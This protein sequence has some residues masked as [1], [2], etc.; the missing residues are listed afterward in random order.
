MIIIDD[1]KCKHGSFSH[2]VSTRYVSRMLSPWVSS[3][4]GESHSRTH[5]SLKSLCNVLP[6]GG[7]LG[8]QF[9]AEYIL[10]VDPQTPL[11]PYSRLC[12]C[13]SQQLLCVLRCVVLVVF[14]VCVCVGGGRGRGGNHVSVSQLWRSIPATAAA[15]A[16]ASVSSRKTHHFDAP[17]KSGYYRSQTLPGL[18]TIVTFNVILILSTLPGQAQP[19]LDRSPA[20]H[21]VAAAVSCST[22]RA[23]PPPSPIMIR[24]VTTRTACR[25][26]DWPKNGKKKKI[27]VRCTS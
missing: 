6:L 10:Y 16:V 17:F 20:R 11:P 15:A 7:L 14:C 25:R 8:P 3:G 26:C 21:V 23:P 12:A 4:G 18:V 24:K 9:P 19:N 5:F 13:V 2:E 1:L 22:L 27:I